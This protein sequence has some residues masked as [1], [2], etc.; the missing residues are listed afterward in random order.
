[1]ELLDGIATTRSIRRYL[2]EPIPDEVMASIMFSASRAPSGS[3]RQQFRFIVLRDSQIAHQAKSLIGTAAR[4][5]WAAKRADE[6]YDEGSGAR[7]DSPKTR[8]ANSMQ[9]YV[10][11]FE[12]VPVLILPA[13]IR[14][15]SPSPHEGASVYPACQNL[16]LAARAHGYG[17]VITVFHYPVEAD[18]RTLLNIP[19]E[20]FLAATMTL[21]KPQGTHGP[22]R[23][24]PLE[25]LIYEDGWNRSAPWAIDPPGTRHT[26]AG[27]PR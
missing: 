8:M 9:Q 20:V 1:M 6:K 12:R 4:E 21:G 2:D 18:L 24:R 3:N 16:L 14:Y 19:D 25:E 22:V 5:L 13:L 26:Q 7:P 17:G 23:R 10:D 11:N 15:R 27:P